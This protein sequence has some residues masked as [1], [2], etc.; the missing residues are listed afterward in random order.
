MW[1]VLSSNLVLSSQSKFCLFLQEIGFNLTTPH[2]NATTVTTDQLLH[3]SV[4]ELIAERVRTNSTPGN[5]AP[6]DTAHLA[7]AIEGGGM[8]GSVSA[9]MAAAIA[10]LDLT[11]AF[12]SIYG[13][14]AG[15]MVGAYMISRQMC[16]DVYTQIMPAAGTKFASQK[17]I[18]GNVGVG[19]VSDLATRV[20]ERS[21]MTLAAAAAAATKNVSAVPMVTVAEYTN[22]NMSMATIDAAAIPGA[23]RRRFA[24]SISTLSGKF[25]DRVPLLKKAPA[26]LSQLRPYLTLHPGMNLTFIL[27]GIMSS[28]SGLRPF[29]METFQQ[30]DAQQ[31]LY[32]VASTVRGGKMETVA[33]G[34]RE[35]DFWDIWV[36]EQEIV[37]ADMERK[38]E[39]VKEKKTRIRRLLRGLVQPIVKGSRATKNLGRRL[40]G[41]AIIDVGSAEEEAPPT[42]ALEKRLEGPMFPG[43]KAMDSLNF[44]RR[45]KRANYQPPKK[46]KMQLRQATEC[47]GNSGRK[48]LFACL[49]SSML[50]P[51]AAGPPIKLLRSNHRK[52]VGDN[53]VANSTNICVDA[54]CCK[55]KCCVVSVKAK[56][57]VYLTFLFILF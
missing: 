3:H 41:R 25:T 27:D 48:G 50:V 54:F 33:F 30:N 36:E 13:S 8:R 38:I 49:E 14:S 17:R 44:R 26:M 2:V 19:Y 32:A 47:P 53:G 52:D 4:I 23:K 24:S 1:R 11:D 6:D 20:R 15:C 34:S 35:G 42:V 21:V 12:D 29:D 37:E 16:V 7:L 10:S 43:I 5:R 31:P 51:G 39:K 22:N 18:L 9:G 55:Y 56:G 28:T 46:R 45:G 40:V 57:H